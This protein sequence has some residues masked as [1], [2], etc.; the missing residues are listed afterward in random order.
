M[1]LGSIRGPAWRAAGL[2]LQQQMPLL[3]QSPAGPCLAAV[4]VMRSGV[5]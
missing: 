3:L 2:L 1:F 4:A 5:F